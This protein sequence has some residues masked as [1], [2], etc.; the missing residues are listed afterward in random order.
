MTRVAWAADMV[1]ATEGRG[2]P[3]RLT[4][5][6]SLGARAFSIVNSDWIVAVFCALV[7]AGLCAYRLTL[8]DV[9]LGVHGYG[10]GVLF[11]SAV[12]LAHGTLPYKDYAYTSPPGATV[13]LAPLGLLGR[14]IGT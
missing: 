3:G 9:L 4:P 12:Q 14:V 2:S 8:H 7:A 5:R 1:T 13:L 6:Q 10:D 11:G